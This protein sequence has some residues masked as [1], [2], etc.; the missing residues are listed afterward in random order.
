[1]IEQKPVAEVIYITTDTYS[2]ERRTMQSIAVTEHL[3]KHTFLFTESQLK[4]ELG[5]KD[6]LIKSLSDEVKSLELQ[7]VKLLDKQSHEEPIA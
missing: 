1:M 2:T 7:L 5:K 6:K 3:D 4:S